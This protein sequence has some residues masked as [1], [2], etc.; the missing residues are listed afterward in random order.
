MFA[1]DKKGSVPHPQHLLN[2]F[3]STIE[4]CQMSELDLNE[5]R[6]TWERS[7]GSELWVREYL[8]KAFCSTNW[9][10]KF[11]LCHLK[12]I[13]T[14]RLDHDPIFLESC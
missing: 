3:Y 6:F 14:S 8:N 12:V 1:S 2:G 4:K 13:Q 9:W 10:S 7:R 5:D 11:S